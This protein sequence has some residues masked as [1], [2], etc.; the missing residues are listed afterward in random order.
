MSLKVGKKAGRGEKL[1]RRQYEERNK[2]VGQMKNT[3]KPTLKK[4]SLRKS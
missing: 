4:A 3:E 1:P 2:A